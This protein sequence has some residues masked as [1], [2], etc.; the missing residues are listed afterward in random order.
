MIGI[1]QVLPNGNVVTPQ[2]LQE[3]K[4]LQAQ[5]DDY[6]DQGQ[7]PPFHVQDKIRQV[8]QASTLVKQNQTLDLDTVNMSAIIPVKDYHPSM[9]AKAYSEN[10]DPNQ[11]QKSSFASLSPSSLSETENEKTSTFVSLESAGSSLKKLFN[12]TLQ[13]SQSSST[14]SAT[15]KSEKLDITV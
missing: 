13:T 9:V 1:G 11:T 3:Y 6:E 5:A 15:R 8:T 12:G 10:T 14:T 4:N 2:M 7:K